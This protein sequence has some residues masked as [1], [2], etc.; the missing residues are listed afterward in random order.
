MT[1]ILQLFII[2]ASVLLYACNHPEESEASAK[3]KK[4]DLTKAASYN[5]Q[6]GLG[7]LKQGDRLRAKRKL[8]M[9]MEQEPGSP[10]VHA[11]IAYFYEQ[12][13]ELDQA[14]KHYVKAISLSSQ[15]GAQLNNYGAFLCRQGEYP[16]AEG[17]F[18]KAVKDI[19]Y[20]NTAGAY[21]NAGLCALA[22]PDNE[23]AKLYFTNAINQD[24]SRK[25]SLYELV[26]LEDKAGNVNVAF[27]LLQQHPD[28]ILNDKVFLAL[29]RDIANRVGKYE[30]A[31]AYE[32]SYAKLES[33]IDSNGVNNE[34]NSRNG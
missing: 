28:L 32:N 18:L 1:K 26:R 20:I 16:K 14:K 23:K 5:T 29:A 27:D 25:Q 2:L 31:A 19:H 9:A 21:E 12:T 17:Y 11:G 22:I 7:Y 3:E 30:I 10:D 33:N 4:A 15:S 24:P 34:Y 6:L 13:G 8:L